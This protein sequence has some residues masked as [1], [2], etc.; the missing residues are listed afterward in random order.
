MGDDYKPRPS[1]PEATEQSLAVLMRQEDDRLRIEELE[2]ALAAERE[3]GEALEDALDSCKYEEDQGRQ[4]IQA[5]IADLAA[6]IERAK[7]AEGALSLM[8]PTCKCP[9]G[10]EERYKAQVTSSAEYTVKARE[11][12]D[13]RVEVKRL[14]RD[15]EAKERDRLAWRDAARGGGK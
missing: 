13:L 5:Y 9:T 3:R 11:C 12:K 10:F 15:L 2:K 1:S 8:C 6:A 4:E 14:K 7:R